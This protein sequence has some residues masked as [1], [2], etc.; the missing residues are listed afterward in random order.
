MRT[1][2]SF[3]REAI[4]VKQA[5]AQLRLVSR[6]VLECPM[7]ESHHHRTQQ[8]TTLQRITTIKN[9][10]AIEK[11]HRENNGISAGTKGLWEFHH[12]LVGVERGPK[13]H[14]EDLKMSGHNVSDAE[15]TEFVHGEYTL[16]RRF[17]PS[18][19]ENES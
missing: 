14:V 2:T 12:R 1:N 15:I 5:C 6:A 19:I 11:E 8:G 9:S 13:V 10:T 18:E 3:G 7:H 4:A 17:G 16:F